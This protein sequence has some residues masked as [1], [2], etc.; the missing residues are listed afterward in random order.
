MTAY[1]SVRT[2]LIR[3]IASAEAALT[4]ANESYAEAARKLSHAQTTAARAYD[5]RATNQ[6]NVDRLKKALEIIEGDG[7]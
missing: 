6:R 3:D 1:V 5:G 7:G 2:A 4:V